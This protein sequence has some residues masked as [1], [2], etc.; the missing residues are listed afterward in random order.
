M[1][2]IVPRWVQLVVLPLSLLALW[3]PAGKVLLIFIVASLIAL[4]LDPLVSLLQGAGLR[5]TMVLSVYVA[6]FLMLVGIGALL[7][8]PVSKQVESFSHNVP[9]IV[10]EAD[11]QIVKFKSL[12]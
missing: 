7:A 6:F 12:R 4:I 1:G 8:N 2:V 10:K 5:G 3:A 11:H 9:S